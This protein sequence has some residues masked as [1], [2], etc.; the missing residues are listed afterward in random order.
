[1]YKL[2]RAKQF[3]RTTRVIFPY[4]DP[5]VKE[6]ALFRG[7]LTIYKNR[8]IILAEAHL[9]SLKGGFVNPHNTRCFRFLYAGLFAFVLLVLAS[10]GG[11]TR[12]CKHI[13]YREWEYET[14]SEAIAKVENKYN[15]DAVEVHRADIKSVNGITYVEVVFVKNRNESCVVN[16]WPSGS[17]S[18]E[19]P[20]THIPT[21]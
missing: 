11:L 6:P 12:A 14:R 5:A 17:V 10:T 13:M 19:R 20:C 18:T 16:V 9:Y 1:M 21:A 3:S 4:S 8:G 2:Q 15:L 7:L